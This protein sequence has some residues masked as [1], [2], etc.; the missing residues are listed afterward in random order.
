MDNNATLSQILKEISSIRESYTSREPLLSE[1][2]P[3]KST[4]QNELFAA[5]AKAQT[6]MPIA[7]KGSINPFFKSS[8]AS[9][10]DI[11]KASRP[12]LSKNGLAVSQNIMER[13]NGQKYLYTVLMHSSGQFMASRLKI[14]PP[15]PDIQEFGKYVSYLKR[16][17]YAALVGVADSEEDDDGETVMAEVRKD[18]YPYKKEENKK[19][20]VFTNPHQEITIS[21]DQYQILNETLEDCPERNTVIQDLEKTFK[22]STLA[23]LPRQHFS[24]VLKH[25]NDTK[26]ALKDR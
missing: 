6:E 1:E 10:C 12:V 16:Y 9:F 15:K 24:K 11:I 17:S 3:L 26:E 2:M 19:D 13:E 20:P 22:I 5:L 14:L 7:S 4:E 21:R 23:D 25:V 8:Y 18:M